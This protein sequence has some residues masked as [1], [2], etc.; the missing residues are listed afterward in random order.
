[1][2]AKLGAEFRVHAIASPPGDNSAAGGG[3]IFDDDDDSGCLGPFG[4]AAE[5]GVQ[6]FEAAK[7]TMGLSFSICSEDWSALFTELAKAVGET[8]T[9]PCALKL[10]R[11]PA[12]VM[13]D[14]NLINVVYTP[15]SGGQ[16]ERLPRAKDAVS[17]GNQRGWH[18]DDP[19]APTGIVLCPASCTVAAGGGELEVALGCT[20]VLF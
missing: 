13:L 19:T 18:Y 8:A 10:P 11:P 15:Q 16:S 20:S 12:G 17:C 14:H 4:A 9:I 6:H 5:P 1:M 3:S 2:R 7:L